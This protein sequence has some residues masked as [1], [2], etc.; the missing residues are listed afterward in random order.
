MAIGSGGLMRKPPAALA[1]NTELDARTIVGGARHHADI[2]RTQSDLTIRELVAPMS[3]TPEIVR[4]RQTSSGRAA[5]KRAVAITLRNRWRHVRVTE[6]LLRD[7][8]ENILMI[9][10]TG[11]GRPKIRAAARRLAHAPFVKVKRRVHRGRLCRPRVD[12]I[13]QV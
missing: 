7:H 4:A 8:A 10:P 1:Q 3:M 9:G 13:I 11:V 12:S 5:Q 6:N 2:C